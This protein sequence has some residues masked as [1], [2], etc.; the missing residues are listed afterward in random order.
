MDS[1]DK[2]VSDESLRTVIANEF[3]DE[4]VCDIIGKEDSSSG[5]GLSTQV[6]VRATVTTG[7][8]IAIIGLLSSG[9]LQTWAYQVLQKN[10]NSAMGALA[11]IIVKIPNFKY[12]GGD[13]FYN[14]SIS[15]KKVR[16]RLLTLGWLKVSDGFSTSI[17][18]VTDVDLT[19]NLT[20]KTKEF[21]EMWLDSY[22]TNPEVLNFITEDG[23]VTA[24]AISAD[25]VKFAVLDD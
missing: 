6:M 24:T 20:V 3:S 10:P 4:Q 5:P 7:V 16:D 1:K 25:A 8:F 2:S 19:P 15:L 21:D 23:C 11:K 14:K 13:N 17:V 9:V 22:S 12:S 18:K